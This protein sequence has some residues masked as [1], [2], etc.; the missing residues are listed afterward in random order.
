MVARN[1]EGK[2]E[3]S[4]KKQ[5]KSKRRPSKPKTTQLRIKKSYPKVFCVEVPKTTNGVVE[6]DPI[7][8]MPII[9]RMFVGE[10]TCF[11]IAHHEAWKLYLW[12]SQKSVVDQLSRYIETPA[13]NNKN[14]KRRIST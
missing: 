1:K 6:L 9:E 5:S 4:S 13:P 12:Q 11:H 7:T 14:K 10:Y 2:G 3:E 8:R